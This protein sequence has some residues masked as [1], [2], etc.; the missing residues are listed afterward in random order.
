MA[1]GDAKLAIALTNQ[2]K[3]A[4]KSHVTLSRERVAI[5]PGTNAKVTV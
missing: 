2:S 1:R 3:S 4:L 5:A